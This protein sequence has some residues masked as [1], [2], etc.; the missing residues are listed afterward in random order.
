MRRVPA[1]L[2][3]FDCDGVL[4]D[5]EAL[6]MEIEARHLTEA[7]FPI[8]ADEIGERFLGLSYASMVARVGEENGRPVPAEVAARLQRDV[9]AAFPARLRAVPGMDELLA[10]L[11]RPRCVAS[12]SDLDR[13][14]LSLDLTRLIG[15]FEREHLFSA[16]MV[17]RGK[18]APDLFLHAATTVGIAPAAC[19][20]VE[21]SPHGVEA[22]V[23]AGMDVIG[24]TAG[25]HAGP[26]LAGRLTAAGASRV[27]TDSDELKMLLQ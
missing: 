3:I 14:R 19:V 13:I 17:E 4:V 9:L 18:P 1:E 2:V 6:G 24:F 21:D 15:H 8:T 12:S 5:S 27:A 11:G 16:Q 25:S 20:V 26:S 10:D 23:A 7:G 22:A